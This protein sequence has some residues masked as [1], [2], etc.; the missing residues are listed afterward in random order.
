MIL[1]MW[2]ERGVEVSRPIAH[3]G[4]GEGGVSAELVLAHL[5]QLVRAELAQHPLVEEHLVPPV[6]SP[7]GHTL[8]AASAMLANVCHTAWH[9]LDAT[10][11]RRLVG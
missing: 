5:E 7:N 9:V 2:R 6:E 8:A 3:E 4:G 11:R 1:D 10:V